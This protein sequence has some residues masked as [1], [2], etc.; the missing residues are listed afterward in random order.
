MKISI[1][2]ERQIDARRAKVSKALIKRIEGIIDGNE[3]DPFEDDA[4]ACLRFLKHL[5]RKD[6]A[7]KARISP[8]KEGW[9]DALYVLPEEGGT[10]EVETIDDDIVFAEFDGFFWW[11]DDNKPTVLVR[12]WR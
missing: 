6:E 5:L 9:Y 10:F 2:E 3:I 8:D 4:K 11:K 12:K 7:A 1:P